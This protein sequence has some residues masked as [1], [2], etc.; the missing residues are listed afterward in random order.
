MKLIVQWVPLRGCGL[1]RQV[2][3]GLLGKWCTSG[4]GHGYRM[5]PVV[6]HYI[7]SNVAKMRII[8]CAVVSPLTLCAW[9]N[10]N[11]NSNSNC[12]ERRNSRF[13]TISSLRLEPSPTRTLKWPRRNR[14]QIMCSTLSAYHVQHVVICA[15]WYEGTVQLV[16]QSLNHIYFSFSFLA[17]PLADEGFYT[18]ANNIYALSIFCCIQFVLTMRYAGS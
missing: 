8:C 5:N 11:N 17:E 15:M 12:T 9:D 18:L 10:N 13:F 6:V 1:S 4:T 16:W 7:L 14:V 3:V 2:A